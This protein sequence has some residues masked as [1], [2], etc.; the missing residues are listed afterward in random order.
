MENASKPTM[1]KNYET[2]NQKLQN[3]TASPQLQKNG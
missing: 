3:L 2:K 1:Q